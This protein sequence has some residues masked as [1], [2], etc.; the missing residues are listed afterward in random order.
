[1]KK[2]TRDLTKVKNI[3]KVL[4]LPLGMFILME[5][6]SSVFFDSHI[7]E[8]KIDTYNF[9]RSVAVTIISSYALAMNM[10]S[11]RMDLSLGGQKMI[12][13]MI[14]GN[15]AINLGLGPVGVLIFCM[16]FGIVSGLIVG[17]L[18]VTF[19]LQSFVLGIGMALLY[20]AISVAFSPNG[21]QLY[22]KGGMS[23]L[24]DTWFILAIAVIVVIAMVLLIQ[25]SKFGAQYNVIKGS[26]RVA[27]N[28]GINVNKN[29]IICFALC[30][31][32]IALSGALET[33]Y[34]GYMVT[35]LNLTS[36]AIAFSG[37]VPVFLVMY[38]QRWCPMMIG[39]PISV[40]TFRFLT[41]GL[42]KLNLPSSASTAI[43]MGILMVFIVAMGVLGEVEFKKRLKIRSL[44]I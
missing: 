13:C 43:T 38:L 12:G 7:F 23:I 9:F 21:F 32:L 15:I 37:F 17:F 16:L 29:A 33:G 26:Q 27:I 3:G 14:G 11:G 10:S 2:K 6:M 24:G 39:I 30:G 22:G 19:R 35:Q 40:V 25:R 31:G 18:F 44:E 5:L 34:T 20:E 1:M 42:M 4:L 36:T 41:M 8:T 28:S